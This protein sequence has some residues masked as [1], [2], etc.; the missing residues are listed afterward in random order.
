MNSSE[1]PM[2]KENQDCI[3]IIDDKKLTYD[4]L[5]EMEEDLERDQEDPTIF[6][7]NK[8]C[9]EAGESERQNICRIGKCRHMK[10]FSNINGLKRHLERDHQRT[11]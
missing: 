9:K 5:K 1:C 6:Y 2:C 7:L 4:D 10:G 11:F 3:F 8:R